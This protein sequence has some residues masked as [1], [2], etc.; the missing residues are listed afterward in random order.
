M[1][2]TLKELS[3]LQTKLAMVHASIALVKAGVTPDLKM[4]SKMLL[5]KHLKNM[6]KAYEIAHE[7]E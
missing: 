5:E 4:G 6:V 2:D 7:V 3:S 1:M